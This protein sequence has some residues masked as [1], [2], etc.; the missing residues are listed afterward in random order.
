MVHDLSTLLL[1]AY[2]NINPT[3]NAKTTI[4]QQFFKQ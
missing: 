2:Y 4:H 1:N 3:W